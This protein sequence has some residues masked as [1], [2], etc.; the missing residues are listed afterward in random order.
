MGGV[1][2][3]YMINPEAFEALPQGRSLPVE[4]CKASTVHLPCTIHLQDATDISEV[5]V[6]TD[7]NTKLPESKQ[8]TAG[9]VTP[10]TP[11]EVLH[12]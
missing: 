7:M 8:K 5:D 4:W 3:I 9:K 2:P 6:C 10:S 12:R 1:L 11:Q